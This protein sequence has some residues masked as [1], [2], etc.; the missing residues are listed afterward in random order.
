MLAKFRIVLDIFTLFFRTILLACQVRNA[1]FYKEEVNSLEVFTKLLDF[2]EISYQ[3]RYNLVVFEGRTICVLLDDKTN[4]YYIGE[5]VYDLSTKT[6]DLN[7]E[8]IEEGEDENYILKKD[9]YVFNTPT[10]CFGEVSWEDTLKMHKNGVGTSF[11]IQ[12]NIKGNSLCRR[13]WRK[14]TRMSQPRRF[15][16][17][18]R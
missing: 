6:S 7:L 13:S 16:Q 11:L 1:E 5:R 10:P 2:F 8:L 14:T 15:P 17:P 18:W 4:K 3:V 9:N 12:V